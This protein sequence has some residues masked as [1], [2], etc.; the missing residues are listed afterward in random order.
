M[1]LLNNRELSWTLFNERVLQEAQD[2]S[3]PLLQRLRFL[4]IFSNNQDEFLKVRVANL[5]RTSTPKNQK[6]QPVTGGYMPGELLAFL[7]QRIEQTQAVFQETYRNIL[8]QMEEQSIYVVNEQQLSE[9]QRKFCREYF[10][11]VVSLR[12]VPL[13][14]RKSIDIPFLPDGK[15][16]LAVKMTG[17][18]TQ[19]T[20]YA[21]IQMPVST[22]CPRFV[23]LPSLQGRTDVIFLDDIIRLALDDLFFMF[24]YNSI[25]AHTFKLTRDAELTIDEDISKSLIEKMEQG[26]TKREHGR[27][28]R[29]IYDQEMP[30]DLFQVIA[31][32]LGIKDEKQLNPSGRY[33]LM[34]DLM[35]FPKVRPELENKNPEPLLHPA[36]RPFASII[37]IIKKQDI[38]LNYPYHT[39][40]HFIDLLHEAAVDPHVEAIYITLYR[41][42]DHSKVINALVNAAKN[43]KRVTALVELKA[44]FDEEQNIDN[45]DLLHNAGVKVIHSLEGLKVHSKLL[46]V[47]RRENSGTLK[48][49]TYIG[50]GNFNENTAEIYSDFG[51]F[52]ANQEIASDARKVFD[53]LQ[54]VHKHH[55]YNHLLVSPYNMRQE[56]K[57]LIDTEIRNARKGKNA[58]IYA[59]FNSLTDEKIIT[60]L[61]KASSAGVKIRLIIRGACC[62]RAGVPGLSDNIKAI[63]IVDKY[64]EHARLV[65]CCNDDKPRSLILSADWMTRNLD[66]RVEVGIFILD[67][68]VHKTLEKIFDIQWHDNVKARD[69]SK[70]ESNE[71][72]S[73]KGKECRSQVELYRYFSNLKQSKS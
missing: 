23:V 26:I 45:S 46:L 10:L 27:P 35:K 13:M 37:N 67:A 21:I 34:R 44:R 54:N 8:T 62:L 50:T 36:I 53:F 6:A 43:G 59:K 9:P 38:L 49:Y 72:V 1:N 14:L 68:E 69:L 32:K 52:T 58:W 60:Q 42:A 19:H 41:T 65:I 55:E 70:S 48:G 40:K 7:N 20:R 11:S 31:R 39:F 63:S 57:K 25:S 66:R 5:L 61:Y 51:L 71:Y 22:A 28:I 4:G 73:S 47:E 3:V 15:I 16:Y 29:L 30:A 24:K 12:L 64:L 56:F 17:E 18:K 33:H 2:L